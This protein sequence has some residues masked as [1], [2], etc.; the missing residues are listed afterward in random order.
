MHY[1]ALS[2]IFNWAELKDDSGKQNFKNV[3]WELPAVRFTQET[4]SSF[5]VFGFPS[6]CDHFIAL[7]QNLQSLL[8]SSDLQFSLLGEVKE[9][10]HGKALPCTWPTTPAFPAFFTAIT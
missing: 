8:L 10:K 9:A 1:V 6:L 4:S 5:V 7:W 2:C 3:F